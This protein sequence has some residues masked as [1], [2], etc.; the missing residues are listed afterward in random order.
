MPFRRVPIAMKKNLKK[1]KELIKLKNK[2]KIAKVNT[3]TD[4]I[5]SLVIV[6]KR[7]NALRICIDPKLLN[8]AL[9]RRHFLLPV[10]EDVL[11]EL[12]SAKCDVK[13]LFFMWS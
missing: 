13:M 6:E 7:S 12:Y 10:V 5:S 2:G 9:K 8:T 4:W 11:C 3:P 1:K